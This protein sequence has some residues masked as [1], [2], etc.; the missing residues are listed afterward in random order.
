VPDGSVL[1]PREISRDVSRERV[2]TDRNYQE[3]E[4]G[5]ID[6]ESQEEQTA[7]TELLR[8]AEREMNLQQFNTYFKSRPT[9]D[10]P[11]SQH[12]E[13]NTKL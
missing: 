4:E 6:E 11:T 13:L 3:E 5:Q 1:A 12:S 9:R 2:V 8:T 7:A 10:S